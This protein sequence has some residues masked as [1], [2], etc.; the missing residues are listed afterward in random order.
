M[1]ART[2]AASSSASWA[3]LWRSTTSRAVAAIE[4]SSARRSRSTLQLQTE[5]VRAALAYPAETS[6]ESAW[7][8]AG[9]S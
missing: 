5:D 3:W 8:L 4:P 1:A 2:C 7:K 9:A 6:H